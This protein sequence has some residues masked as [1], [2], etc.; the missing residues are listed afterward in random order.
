M[1]LLL[2]VATDEEEAGPG[3]Y[4]VWF[5]PNLGS[6]D[7]LELFRQPEL[8][9]EARTHVD[10]LQLYAQHLASTAEECPACGPNLRRGFLD[11]VAF[12]RLAAWKLDLAVETSAL[13]DWGCRAHPHVTQLDTALRVAGRV[14]WIVLDEPRLGAD[15]CGLSVAE[16][17]REVAGVVAAARRLA[18]RARVGLVEPWPALSVAQ[19]GEWLDA[20]AAHGATVE[21]LH[22]DVDRRYARD[23][24]LRVAQGLQDVA[25]LAGRRGITFGVILWGDAHPE[26]AYAREVRGWAR[27]VD[28]ALGWPEHVIFQSWAAAPDGTRRVPVNLPE[29]E[30][31]T[32]TNL[33]REILLR[34]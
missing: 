16:A 13:K 10:V 18:P 24:G 6:L 12:D 19:I 7:L 25:H 17:A 3:P 9:P 28:D 26:A 30:P 14:D 32:H 22:L 33:V 21:F 5:A 4:L 29:D 11:A 31:G 34:R 27:E 2:A 20:L 1:G 8:W 23:K 15:A